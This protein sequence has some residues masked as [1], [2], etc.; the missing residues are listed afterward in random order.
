MA[1]PFR[2][3]RPGDKIPNDAGAFNAFALAAKFARD[4]RPTLSDEQRTN[5]RSGD[6]IRVKNKTSIDLKR[7]NIVGLDAPIF[8]PT[9]SESAFLREVTF[10]GVVPDSSHVGKFAVLLE[11]ALP[12]RVVK[13]IVSGVCLVRLDVVDATHTHADIFPTDV[14]ALVTNDYG[15]AQV[16]WI[17]N[18]VYDGGYDGYYGADTKWA[19]VRIGQTHDV[20]IARATGNIGAASGGTY[21]SGPAVLQRDTGTGL[22]DISS[23]TITV[24]NLTSKTILYTTGSLGANARMHVARA[25]NK[26]WIID[27]YDC[28]FLS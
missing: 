25:M 10:R 14:T 5:T 7:G 11:P 2:G 15:S 16:L 3:Y 27:I 20:T 23:Q 9:D 17:D 21:G 13:A 4:A 18:G 1:D 22:V 12:D 19:V 28:G 6:I 24:Y 26:W 8:T